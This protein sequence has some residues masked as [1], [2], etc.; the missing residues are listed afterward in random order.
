MLCLHDSIRDDDPSLQWRLRAVEEA[1][2]L[3][4]L[5]LATWQ[6]A[7]VLAVH[8]IEAV[9]LGAMRTVTTLLPSMASRPPSAT[10]GSPYAC[11]D[12]WSSSTATQG[13]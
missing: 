12:S 4:A 3:T 8:V 11:G 6:V 2:S 5:V 1:P 13:T 7:H 9:L 10:P